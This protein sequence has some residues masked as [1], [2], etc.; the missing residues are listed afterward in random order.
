MSSSKADLLNKNVD[1]MVSESVAAIRTISKIQ[2]RVAVILGSGLG[3]FADTIERASVIDY[4]SIPHFPKLSAAGHRG[5]LLLGYL[6]AMPVVA[7]R[8]RAHLYEGHPATVATYG[9]RVMQAL[10]AEILIVSNAAGG[11]SSRYQVGDLVLI[12][13][14]IDLMYQSGLT[15]SESQSDLHAMGLVNRHTPTYDPV[16]RSQMKRLAVQHGFSLAEGTYLATLGPTYETRAEY[17]AFRALGA[18]LVGMSTVPEVIL[19]KALGMKVLAMSV[20]TNVACPDI[21]VKT[22]HDEVLDAANQAQRRMV[23]VVKALLNE[24]AGPPD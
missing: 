7:M 23:L 14:H 12:D 10:G 21:T 20:V 19:G 16:L 8:G 6:G 15:T 2:P 18:D 17:R 1:A 4:V 5:E 11:L 3:P 22:T 24:L 13:S 9:V